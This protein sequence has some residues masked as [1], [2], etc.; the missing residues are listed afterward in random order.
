MK[1]LNEIS[2]GRGMKRKFDSNDR[3]TDGFPFTDS[4][5]KRQKYGQDELELMFRRLMIAT[6]T[7]LS[8]INDAETCL[9]RCV[10]LE[11]TKQK[12]IGGHS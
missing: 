9:R 5:E 1:S 7:K 12:A 8:V 3:T 10:L 4:S 11:R 6:E 2:Y